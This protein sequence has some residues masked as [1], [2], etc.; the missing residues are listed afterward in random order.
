VIL[1]RDG[2]LNVPQFRDGRSFAPRREED[3]VLYAD[4]AAAVARLKTAGF[5]VVVATNQP[6]VGAGL[7]ERR[8]VDAMH[9]RLRHEAAVDDI[10][11]CYDPSDR[12]TNRRKPGIGML[13]DLAARW[14]IDLLA[15]YMVGDRHGDIEAGTNAG[16][17]AIFVDR[18]YTSETKPTRQAVTVRSLGEAA[19]WILGE[20]DVAATTQ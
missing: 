1:D 10:E 15:S 14:D 3:F 5:L 18:D 12:A 20:T 17:V 11:V 4:A 9:A 2:V 16:C 7:V 6:D 19:T 13:L 8:V